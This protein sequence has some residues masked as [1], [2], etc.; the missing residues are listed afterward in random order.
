MAYTLQQLQQMG[1][2]PVQPSGGNDSYTIDQLQKMGANPVI[3]SVQGL[4]PPTLGGF[5]AKDIT[6]KV[7]ET[8]R[9]TGFFKGLASDIFQSTLGSEGAAGLAQAPVRPIATAIGAE[10]Q[11]GMQ[12]NRKKLAD[13]ANNYIVMAHQEQNPERKRKLL[14]L[15]HSTLKEGD[16]IA[17]QSQQISQATP[18]SESTLKDIERIGGQAVNT[19]L[20][21]APFAKGIPAPA[22]AGPLIGKGLQTLGVG[23]TTAKR[24]VTVGKQI[25][26]RAIESAGY[27]AGFGAGTAL[28][29]EKPSGEVLKSTLAGGGFGLAFPFAGTALKAAANA[30]GNK[31]LRM[32]ASAYQRAMRPSLSKRN[33][34]KIPSI[35]ET[36]LKEGIALSE[37]GVQKVSDTIDS[38]EESLGNAIA[39]AGE[40]GMKIKTATLLPFVQEAKNQ[41]KNISDVAYAEKA[42]RDIDAI[43]ANFRKKYGASIPVE[44]AQEIKTSTYRWLKD[45]YGELSSP[46]KEA[47]KQLVRGLKE[48]IVDVAPRVRSINPRLKKLYE[49]DEALSRAKGRIGNLNLLGL[50]AKIFAAAGVAGGTK[51][52]PILATIDFLLTSPS[53]RS[54]RAIVYDRVGRLLNRLTPDE[55]VEAFANRPVLKDIYERFTGV[56]P[57]GTPPKIPI[58]LSLVKK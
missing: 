1:A 26:P 38:L 35:I 44:I 56:K 30:P 48:G 10:T 41:I 20:A 2:K 17:Q 22:A 24:A 18:Q 14:S 12:E 9:P 28:A 54:R 43:Y 45:A 55:K 23:A 58:G 39:K 37:R 42:V 50:G 47:N 13:T 31:L 25:V 29:E 15:A 16:V 8:E 40:K 19:A 21:F 46:V 3:E 4:P 32:A 5:I 52:G 33:I 27:G 6:G 36:G 57:K 7:A 11:I 34:G 53:A 51:L 49:F